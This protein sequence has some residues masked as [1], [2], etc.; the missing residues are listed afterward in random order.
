MQ[1]TVVDFAKDRI[2]YNFTGCT[3]E[4]LENKLNL[5]FVS[6]G[7]TYK[8]EKDGGK[9]YTKGN[10]V[11][12]AILGAFWKYFKLFVSIKNEGDLYSVMVQKDASGFMGGA[13]G[14]MQVNKEFSR[15]TEAFKPY[16]A[17]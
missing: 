8:G 6:Q 10:K 15:I 16:F 12:R 17:N 1:A 4:E 14:V 11:L 5:F 7:Y 2:V 3:K 9:I 13:I